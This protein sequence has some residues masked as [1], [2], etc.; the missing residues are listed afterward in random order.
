MKK[1][2]INGLNA[3]SGGGKSILNNY[4]QILKENL[5]NNIYY[6]LTPNKLEYSKFES[7]SIK[8]IDV[9]SVFK[10]SIAL[11]FTYRFIL[12]RLVKGYEINTIFNLADI[13]IVT[14][15][16]QV[17]LF[18][19]PYAVYPESRVWK[20]M[21]IKD[22]YKRKFKL[23]FFERNIKYVDHF[24]VQTNVISKRLNYI[25][26][27]ASCTVI[28]NAVT[29]QSAIDNNFQFN[30]PSGKKLLYLTYYYPHKNIE[31]LLDLARFIRESKSDYKLIVTIDKNQS[32][33]ADLFLKKI[34]SE[35]LSKIIINI[36]PVKM[37]NVSAL[38]RQVDAMLMPTL[39]ETYGLPYIEAFYNDVL[40]FTSDLD[41]AHAVCGSAAKYFNPF[42]EKDILEKI[43]SVFNSS[44]EKEKMLKFG[45]EKLHEIF[46][47]KQVFEKYNNIIRN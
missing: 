38:F 10:L 29:L 34:I 2:L 25:Y 21:S 15:I 33:R 37:K 18:D 20:M 9:K 1:I 24:I 28:P 6:V 40:V 8:I 22:Y 32:K 43:E 35:N 26:N 4:L 3:K 13:P 30:L 41:F 42:D 19:W 17:F 44:D 31:I 7:D 39:L 11:P 5:D 12:K 45:K 36:G 47:W 23:F 27:C 46:T 14:D 16:Y